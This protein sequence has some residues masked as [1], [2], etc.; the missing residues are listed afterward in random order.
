MEEALGYFFRAAL[1]YQ[2]KY[3]KVPVLIIDNANKLARKQQDVLDALQDYAKLAADKRIAT[4]V[5]VSSEGRVPRCMM[6]KS[7]MLFINYYLLN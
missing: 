4:I 2:Q 3:K 6:G 5:F 7:V 1:K